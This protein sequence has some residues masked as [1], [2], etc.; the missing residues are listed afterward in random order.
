MDDIALATFFVLLSQKLL[1]W[2]QFICPDCL[3]TNSLMMLFMGR[4]AANLSSLQSI[5]FLK[6]LLL[7]GTR[8]SNETL[9]NVT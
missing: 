9:N 7:T 3:R 2:E 1:E 8:P 6:P 5:H 4:L